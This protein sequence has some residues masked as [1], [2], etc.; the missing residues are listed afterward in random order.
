MLNR[1]GKMVLINELRMQLH[2]E[3]L[4]EAACKTTPT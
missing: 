3:Q 4:A 2:Q 1:D